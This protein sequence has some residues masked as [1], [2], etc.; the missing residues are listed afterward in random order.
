M[1]SDLR[2]ILK[3]FS[4]LE[5]TITPGPGQVHQGLNSQQK[6]AHQ[7]PALF[8]PKKIQ[9]IGSKTDPKHPM[10]GLAVGANESQTP[11]GGSLA[12]AM[13]ELEE[14]M[15]DRVRRDLEFY[16]DSLGKKISDDGQRDRDSRA[17]VDKLGEKTKIDRGF[18]PRSAPVSEDPTQQDTDFTPPAAPIQNPTLPESRP[19]KTYMLEDGAVLEIHGDQT[20][21]F[22]VRRGDRILPTKFRNIDDADIAVRL[23]Q[24]SRRPADDSADYIEER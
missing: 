5:G 13:N 18:I 11:A 15:L 7:L 6:S 4:V 22:E 17:P 9:A 24:Q 2:D 19:V 10:T 12:E 20:Q 14:D 8:K 16:L 1:S 21:G 3:R 23:W